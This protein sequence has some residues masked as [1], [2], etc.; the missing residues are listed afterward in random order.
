MS[1][2]RAAAVAVARCAAP[3]GCRCRSPT[4]TATRTSAAGC[5][6]S[7]AR[8]QVAGAVHARRRGGAARRRGQAAARDGRV[9]RGR[10]RHGGA[11]SAGR[12]AAADE[13]WRDRGSARGDAARA[14][15]ARPWTRCSSG[16]ECRAHAPRTHCS[17]RWSDACATTRRG[18]RRG[19]D[20]GAARGRDAARRAR[21]TR[22]TDT[23]RRRD[24]VAARRGEGRRGGR[25]RG[26]RARLRR[27]GSARWSRSRARTSWIAAPDGVLYRYDGGN[28]GLATSGSGD[29]LAGIVA[30]LSA[31]GAPP[32]IAVVW[33]VYVHGER[34]TRARAAH[35]TARLSRARATCRDSAASSPAHLT[36]PAHADFA[37]ADAFAGAGA[38]SWRRASSAR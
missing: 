26:A 9:V 3:S 6:W 24:G 23:A 11:G 7:A 5:W 1:R 35:G 37:G 17:L 33:G 15:C 10:T 31:R 28:V 8:T 36:S 12:R 21:R 34:R 18:A 16:R 13:T 14:A 25:A 29:T 38:S 19:R 2:A 30:G 27:E 32:L 22:R 4:P 20:P